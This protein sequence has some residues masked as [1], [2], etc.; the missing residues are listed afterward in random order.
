MTALFDRRWDAAR[1]AWER[2]SDAPRLLLPTIAKETAI[3]GVIS[4]VIVVRLEC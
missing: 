3:A 1:R 2:S 4:R